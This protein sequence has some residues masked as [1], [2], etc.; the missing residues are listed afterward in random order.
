MTKVS[1]GV[2]NMQWFMENVLQNEQLV[3]WVNALGTIGAV[4]VAL[5][6]A[7]RQDKRKGKLEVSDINGQTLIMHPNKSVIDPVPVISFTVYNYSNFSITISSIKVIVWERGFFRKK[8]IKSAIFL[9]DDDLGKLSELPMTLAPFESKT[10]MYR[11]FLFDNFIKANIE[12]ITNQK[13]IKSTT[14]EFQA[15]DTFGKKYMQKQKVNIGEK[16][17]KKL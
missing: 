1:V 17:G 14:Y 9:I 2:V 13:R 12:P 7:L 10:W 3:N 6:L 8:I 11:K 4:W 16:N 15:I 5:W